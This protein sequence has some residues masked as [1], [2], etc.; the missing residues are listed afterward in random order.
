ME[1]FFNRLTKRVE[2]YINEDDII[3]DNEYTLHSRWDFFFTEKGFP[4]L[5]ILVQSV[6]LA[7]ICLIVPFERQRYIWDMFMNM[8]FQ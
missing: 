8:F 2:N 5:N 1:T 4:L 3:E 7:L 6:V